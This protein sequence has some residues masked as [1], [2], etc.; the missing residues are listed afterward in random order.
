[1]GMY[2]VLPATAASR[3]NKKRQAKGDFSNSP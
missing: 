3:E 2:F 1:V